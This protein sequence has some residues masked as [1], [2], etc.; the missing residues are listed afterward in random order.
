MFGR[1][2]ELTTKS[3]QLVRADARLLVFPT[4]AAV[5]GLAAGLGVFLAAHGRAWWAYLAVFAVFVFPA[6]VV[7]TYPGRRVRRARAARTRRAGALRQGRLPLREPPAPGDPRVVAP[8]KPRRPR[9]AGASRG[10]RRLG[11]DEARRLRA[12]PRLGGRDVL[13]RAGDRARG[14]GRRHGGQAL[15]EAGATALG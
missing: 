13:R 2:W 12:R 14:S 7:G 5:L 10:P 15:R 9:L 11:R 3:W 1:G 4:L 6:S 8:R